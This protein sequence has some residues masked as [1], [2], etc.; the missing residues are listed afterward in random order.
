MTVCVCVF[1]R[2]SECVSLS[3]RVSDSGSEVS[4]RGFGVGFG[5][6]APGQRPFPSLAFLTLELPLTAAPVS[7][8]R[9]VANSDTLRE[10]FN[11]RGTPLGSC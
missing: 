10:S 6:G 8:T 4:S 1:E 2:V 7:S 3:L 11:E 5:F 9:P